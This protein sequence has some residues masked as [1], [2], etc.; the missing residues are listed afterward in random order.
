MNQSTQQT[1]PCA[2]DQVF[3][4]LVVVLP[5]SGMKIRSTD[6]VIGRITASTG[7][8][9]ISWG[10][11]VTVVVEKS[12][13]TAV[14]RLASSSKVRFNVGGAHRHHKNFEKIIARLIKHLQGLAGGPAA[15]QRR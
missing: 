15:T 13:D 2:Y 9:L 8:S 1:F 4:G 6:K 10:E 7:T 11:N 14:V 12:G 3:D 5:V